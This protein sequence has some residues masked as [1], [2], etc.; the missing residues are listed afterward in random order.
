MKKWFKENDLAKVVMLSILVT[1]VLT[2]I[3]PNGSIV[4]TEF[5]KLTDAAGKTVQAKLGIFELSVSGIYAVSFF[6]QQIIFVLAIGVFYGVISITNGY[7]K[8]VETCAKKIKGKEIPVVLIVSALIAAFVSFSSQTLAVLIIIPF[9]ITVLLNAKLD[10]KTAFVATFGSIFVGLM[11][12]TYGSEGLYYFNYYLTNYAQA[13]VTAFDDTSVRFIILLVAYVIFNV[14]NVMHIKK[15]LADK[16]IDDTKEDTFAVEKTT[17]KTTKVW[18]MIVIIAIAAIFMILGYIRWEADF[19]IKAFANFHKKLMDINILKTIIGGSQ[20]EMFAQSIPSLTAFGAFEIYT[21]LPLLLVLAI[22]SIIVYRVSITEAINGALNGAKKM[23]KPVLLM[24]LAYTIFVLVYWSPI[25]PRLVTYVMKSD[26]NVFTSTIGAAISS[27]FVSDFGYVGYQLGT[28]L[29]TAYAADLDKIY[30]IFPAVYG[31][32]QMIAPT[33]VLLLVG[34]A[35]TNV[36]YKDWMKHIWKFVLI[37]LV[38]L[39][40]IFALVA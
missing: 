22:V 24:V 39:L 2:W 12:A 31:F 6:L 1:L 3:V 13:K 20:N 17:A 33:S 23:I 28:F 7:K 30:V 32:I 25:V 15:V 27:L 8:L 26:F 5:T 35:Y 38:A 18:P 4:G 19:E 11:G 40:L 21:I 10:K 36:S 37:M 16:K 9:I 34:L 29:N 14:F